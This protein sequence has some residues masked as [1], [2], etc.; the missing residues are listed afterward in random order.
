MT[1]SCLRRVW[2][3]NPFHSGRGRRARAE[4]SRSP[5]PHAQTDAPNANHGGRQPAHPLNKYAIRLVLF[6]NQLFVWQSCR[7]ASGSRMGPGLVTPHRGWDAGPISGGDGRHARPGARGC[8]DSR[9]ATVA[10][11]WGVQG[12]RPVSGGRRAARSER[13]SGGRRRHCRAAPGEVRL[14]LLGP[15]PFRLVGHRSPQL[16][17]VQLGRPGGATGTSTCHAKC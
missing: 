13:P 5:G 16:V 3:R 12:K 4:G 17:V 7:V 6:N 8:W 15:D 11:P 10:A 2:P 1:A 9:N 14:L